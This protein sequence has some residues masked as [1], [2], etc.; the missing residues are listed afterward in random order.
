MVWIRFLASSIVLVV[1]AVKMA[2]YGDVI[3]VRTRLGGMFIGVLLLAGATSL[4]E[5][6]TMISSFRLDAP[7]LA[8]GNMFGSN[9]FNMFLLAVLD[10]LHQHARILRRVAMTHA[11]TAALGSA[12]IGLSIFFILGDIDLKIGW[13]GLDSLTLIL[14]YIA[15]IR[16]IQQN[17]QASSTAVEV[18]P[19]ETVMPLWRAAT[20]FLVA[21]GVLVLVTPHLVG[22]SAEIAEVTGLGVGLV[23]TTL[24]AMVTSLPET[25]A[26]V[27][28]CRLGAYDM[29]V[30]NLF[31]SNVFN[32]F[33][34]GVADAFYTPGR[35][36]G[37]I[38]PAFALV[39]M[40]GL[41]LTNLALIGNIARV[42]RRLLFVEAD[43]LLILLVYL[44]G[45]IFL[46]VKGIG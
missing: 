35:L 20:G 24:L 42:E 8:A 7:G 22:S 19:V 18:A 44:G 12:M 16:L 21:T 3:A 9:M 46:Y 38:D 14:V 41:L 6:L 39:G 25:V 28:A 13:M 17:G 1:S 30:G 43:A 2:Q 15:G 23:G 37:A 4:P 10:L 5:M 27:A 33:A 32:M 31:G 29:A 40:L 36:L 34:L 11:L 45:M 26:V